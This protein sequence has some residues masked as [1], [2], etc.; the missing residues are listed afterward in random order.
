MKNIENST[1]DF[2][3]TQSKISSEKNSILIEL[4]SKFREIQSKLEKKVKEA[5]ANLIQQINILKQKEEKAISLATQCEAIL[6]SSNPQILKQA[7]SIQKEIDEFHSDL[8][9]SDQA[10][11]IPD[12]QNELVPPFQMVRI[13]IPN[14]WKEQV[15]FSNSNDSQFLYSE[16]R[17]ICGNKWRAKIYPNG[18]LSGRGTH[19]S[20]FVELVRGY[21]IPSKYYYRLEIESQKPHVN[22]LVRQYSSIFEYEDSWGWNK[23]ASLETIYQNGY[24]S[25]D[26]KLS[27]L[28]GIR[29]ESYY[30]MYRDI[31][32]SISL[33]KNKIKKIQQKKQENVQKKNE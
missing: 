13:E 5:D 12:I 30:Q 27:L 24:L 21:K 31:N 1:H 15:K 28:L 23:A 9:T 4:H 17:L 11:Q 8:P 18:N 10:I 3:N 25:Q 19:L 20:V 2:L 16:K 7:S 29:P 14:F 22:N 33:M 6:D 26:G 32:W